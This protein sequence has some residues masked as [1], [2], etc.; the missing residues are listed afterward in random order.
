MFHGKSRRSQDLWSLTIAF[1]LPGRFAE[2]ISSVEFEEVQRINSSPGMDNT[3]FIQL[4]EW[5]IANNERKV[6]VL[7]RENLPT[8]STDYIK[9]D[10]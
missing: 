2:L 6:E 1:V 4:E 7:I 8:I 10:F 3:P 5:R 9:F